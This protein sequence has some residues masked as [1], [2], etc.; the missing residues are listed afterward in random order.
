MAAPH[1]TTA[2][3]AEHVSGELVGP[4][5]VTLTGVEALDRASADQLSFIVS[6]SYGKKWAESKAGAAIVSRKVELESDG[7][8]LVRVDD[9]ELAMAKALE[10]FA[11]PVPAPE[12]GIDATAVVHPDAVVGEGVAIGPFC[13]VHAGA[14]LGRGVVLH[15]RVEVFGDTAIGDHT[16]IWSGCVIRERCTVGAHAILHPSVVIGAD[17]FGYRPAADGS[18]LVKVPQIGTVVIEDRVE[19]G[20]GTCIDRGKFS[21]TTIGTGTKIDNLC[22]IGHNVT[23]GP[24]CVIAGMA[25][26]AGSVTIGAGVQMGGA[27]SIA[28][29]KTIGDGARL[30]GRAGIICDIPPG[31]SWVGMP[32]KEIRTKVKEEVCVAKLPEWSKT[33][34][35]LVRESK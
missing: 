14:T 4:G 17:G 24:H 33:I 7:R 18:G 25:A 20:A 5:D 12:P 6:K 31:E 21:A 30:S 13:V 35:K 1:H 32:A 16:V 19:I 15:S 8:P 23:I 10:L 9:A 2:S 27:A 22:Q 3:I 11:P 28:P 29:H 34:K 26:I